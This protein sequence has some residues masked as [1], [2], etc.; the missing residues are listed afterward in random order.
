MNPGFLGQKTRRVEVRIYQ[1]GVL[2]R[3]KSPRA[4]AECPDPGGTMG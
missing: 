1:I 2:D 4:W 3:F